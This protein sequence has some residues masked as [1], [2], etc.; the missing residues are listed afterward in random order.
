TTTFVSSI[1]VTRK[2]WRGGAPARTAEGGLASRL[3]TEGP[4]CSP[5]GPDPTAW[6]RQY[7]G[8]V[9][10]PATAKSMRRPRPLPEFHVAR[11]IR[12]SVWAALENC[13][14]DDMSRLLSRSLS[15]ISLERSQRALAFLVLGL[16]D[17]HTKRWQGEF[18]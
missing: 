16:E 7:P 10:K 2:V 4:A 11:A 8:N 18:N 9:H 12:K 1:T 17:D 14:S 15:R 5:A 13:P 3:L 6:T